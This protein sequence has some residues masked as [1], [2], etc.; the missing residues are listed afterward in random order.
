[1]AWPGLTGRRYKDTDKR[2]TRDHNCRH[3]LAWAVWEEPGVR[4]LFLSRMALGISLS[5]HQS[6]HSPSWETGVPPKATGPMPRQRLSDLRSWGPCL[7]NAG[8]RWTGRTTL[9]EL[10]WPDLCVSPHVSPTPGTWGHQAL[11]E[12]EPLE[13]TPRGLIAT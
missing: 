7:G 6:L 13:N 3:K 1:M 4:K 8:T 11:A 2:Q 5:V 12:R 10:L 9:Q